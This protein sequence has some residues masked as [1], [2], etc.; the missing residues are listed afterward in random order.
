LQSIIMISKDLQRYL[1]SDS[2]WKF[3]TKK[4][5]S[6]RVLH[7]SDM[8]YK[9]ER[10]AKSEKLLQIFKECQQNGFV[11]LLTGKESWS[12]LK[13]RKSG[14]CTAPRDEV[15]EKCEQQLMRKVHNFIHLRYHWN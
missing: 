3:V 11:I 15:P 12:V 13:Y 9:N 4:F 6:R 5:K 1:S 14:I 8:N 10:S 2:M 7:K